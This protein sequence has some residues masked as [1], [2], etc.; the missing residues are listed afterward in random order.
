MRYVLD[1]EFDGVGGTLI[2]MSLV[3]EDGRD[4]YI[5]TDHTEI[6]DPW[7]VENI[8]PILDSH[9]CKNV[10][11]TTQ[12]GVGVFLRDFLLHDDEPVIISDSTADIGYFT[13]AYGKKE[14]GEYHRLGKKR[15]SFRVEN[16]RPYPTDLENVTR[17]N[18]HG[19]CL[20]L[21]RC[22]G[23][24]E[25]SQIQKDYNFLDSVYILMKAGL[26]V[27]AREMVKTFRESNGLMIFET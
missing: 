2:S 23:K 18:A 3:G 12:D 26:D 10:I 13:R 19:D 7:V 22:L 21:W 25:I 1:T 14:N 9:T 11:K 5:L 27:Q 17:H 16:V 6:K 20:A 8:I 24:T 15:I 4:I